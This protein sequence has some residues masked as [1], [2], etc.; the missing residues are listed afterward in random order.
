MDEHEILRHLLDLEK[1][2]AALIDDA[3]AEADRRISEGEK[4]NRIRFDDVYAREL[5]A[6]E[7]SYEEKIAAVNEDFRKQLEDY[8]K[9]LKAV[10]PNLKA[11][12]SIAGKLLRVYD[13]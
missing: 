12:S 11:F 6:L 1:E 4:A 7:S 13:P 8:R 9:N 5:E 2:A 3:Q 10:S